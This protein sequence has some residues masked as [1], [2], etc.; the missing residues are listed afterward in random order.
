MK[1]HRPN[2]A[3]CSVPE[4]R[5]PEMVKRLEELSWKV[6]QGSESQEKDGDSRVG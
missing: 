1:L 6:Q 3:R 4:T 5:G 2:C